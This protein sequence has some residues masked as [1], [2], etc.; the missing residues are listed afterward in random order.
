MKVSLLLAVFCSVLWSQVSSGTFFGQA[1]D[2]SG[3]SVSGV[4]VTVREEKTNF[5]RETMTDETGSYHVPDWIQVFTPSRLSERD[6]GN[7][8][9]ST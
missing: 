7:S 5:L 4:H 8:S 6:F 3:A 1:Q 9:Q 2:Q